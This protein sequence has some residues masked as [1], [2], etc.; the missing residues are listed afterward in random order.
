MLQG[1]CHLSP[2][3]RNKNETGP[4]SLNDC[5]LEYGRPALTWHTRIMLLRRAIRPGLPLV[6][7]GPRANTSLHTHMSRSS[8][9]LVPNMTTAL[10]KDCPYNLEAEGATPSPCQPAAAQLWPGGQH[11]WARADWGLGSDSCE[12]THLPDPGTGTDLGPAAGGVLSSQWLY[13]QSRRI[14]LWNC[15]GKFYRPTALPT[16]LETHTLHYS[17]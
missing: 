5:D 9:V 12:W 6:F 10:P 7:E 3:P 15:F 2:M 1:L 4:G 13:Q 14:L 8:E 11:R 16:P 17:I